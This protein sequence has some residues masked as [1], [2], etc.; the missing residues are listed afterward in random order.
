MK[1]QFYFKFYS[2]PQIKKMLNGA[3]ITLYPV[4]KWNSL[5]IGVFDTDKTVVE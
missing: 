4:K 1:V 5:F 3:C 2:S